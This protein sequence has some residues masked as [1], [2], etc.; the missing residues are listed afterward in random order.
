MPST[1]ITENFLSYMLANPCQNLNTIPH[2]TLDVPPLLIVIKF[3]QFFVNKTII[4]ITNNCLLVVKVVITLVY[5]FIIDKSNLPKKLFDARMANLMVINA[6]HIQT[7]F[8]Y[9]RH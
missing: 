4:T 7:I 2:S 5:E 1:A 9:W 8:D 6:E 3:E